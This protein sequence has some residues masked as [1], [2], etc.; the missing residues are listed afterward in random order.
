MQVLELNE[1]PAP[2]S[3]QETVPVGVVGDAD[4]SVTVD[5]NVIGLPAATEEG[6]G[7]TAVEVEWG[8]GGA[9]IVRDEVPELEEC[10]ESPEYPA[11]MVALA[12]DEGAVYTTWQELVL[13]PADE[14]GQELELKDPPA[15]PS[16]HETEPEGVVGELPVSVTVAVKVTVPPAVTEDGL[17]ETPVEVEWGAGALTVKAPLPELV[18]CVESPEYDPD[19]VT[20]A[21][22]EGAV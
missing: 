19:I 17:G 6:L 20:L 22:A 1:P 5:V 14:R 15:P 2:P 21:A 13:E 12:P 11:V 8:G 7:E 4:E 3:T 9:W 16:L 18:A 10:A